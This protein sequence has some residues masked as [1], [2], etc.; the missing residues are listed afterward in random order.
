MRLL[1]DEQADK[2][3]ESLL[4]SVNFEEECRKEH[5]K[6]FFGKETKCHIHYLNLLEKASFGISMIEIYKKAGNPE[7]VDFNKL[8][9]LLDGHFSDSVIKELGVSNDIENIKRLVRKL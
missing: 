9:R 1:T 7:T 5:M 4:N 2:V 6:I 8:A 3:V